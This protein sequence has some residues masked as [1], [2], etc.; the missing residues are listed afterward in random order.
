MSMPVV[1]L[2]IYT[3]VLCTDTLCP[4]WYCWQYIPMFYVLTSCPIMTL[5]II[6]TN[7]IIYQQSVSIMALLITKTNVLCTDNLPI[8]ASLT[9]QVM[10]TLNG[11]AIT[12]TGNLVAEK[13]IYCQN[14]ILTKSITMGR[15]GLSATLMHLQKWLCQPS[16]LVSG[17]FSLKHC[18]SKAAIHF[19]Y[20]RERSVCRA[21]NFNIKNAYYHVPV[22]PSHQLIDLV[23]FVRILE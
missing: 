17:E 1:L 9:W 16:V 18:P 12:P 2:A 11:W 19:Q 20:I 21:F 3:N 15:Y 13:Q 4:W 8:I 5:L 23:P 7:D 22:P 6:N 14:I 10:K